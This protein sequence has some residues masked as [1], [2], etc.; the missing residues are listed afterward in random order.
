MVVC[1]T[2]LIVVLDLGLLGGVKHNNF[3]IDLGFDFA[4]LLESEGDFG[5]VTVLLLEFRKEEEETVGIIIY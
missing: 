2:D 3:G 1:P 4:S 5:E